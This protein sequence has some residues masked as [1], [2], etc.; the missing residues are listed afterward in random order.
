[1]VFH[2]PTAK[3]WAERLR[4]PGLE[5]FHR[6]DVVVIIQYDRDIV[7]LALDLAI[8]YRVPTRF[9]DGGVDPFVLEH[10]MQ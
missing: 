4:V 2:A 6:F 8:D 5:R 7:P 9:H 3:E 10:P 1:V